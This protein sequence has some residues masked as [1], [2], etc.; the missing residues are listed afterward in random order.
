M[1]P[2]LNLTVEYHYFFYV[3]RVTLHHL[4]RFK[5]NLCFC[6]E[7]ITIAGYITT[8]RVSMIF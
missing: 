5:R 7:K 8:G 3:G 2:K 1:R 4:N 6:R